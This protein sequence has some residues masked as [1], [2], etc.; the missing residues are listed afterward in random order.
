MYKTIVIVWTKDKPQADQDIM[1]IAD[2]VDEGDAYATV[3]KSKKV[4]DLAD[5]ADLTDDVCEFFGLDPEDGAPM[6]DDEDDPLDGD[7]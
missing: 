5:D 3:G 1:E 2:L 4:I 6:D 7:D